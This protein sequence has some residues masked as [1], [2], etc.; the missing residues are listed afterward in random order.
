MESPVRDG[1]SCR[2]RFDP[3]AGQPA[4]DVILIVSQQHANLR[5]CHGRE[6]AR[7]ECIFE[8]EIA[9]HVND[10]RHHL[11]M[12]MCKEQCN[13][14]SNRVA[15]NMATGITPSANFLCQMIRLCLDGDG[16]HWSARV[17]AVAEHVRNDCWS[18]RKETCS[19]QVAQHLKNAVNENNGFHL[20]SAARSLRFPIPCPC[21]LQRRPAPAAEPRSW[22]VGALAARAA[23]GLNGRRRVRRGSGRRRRRICSRANHRPR[24]GALRRDIPL[25]IDRH[26]DWPLTP[27]GNRNPQRRSNRR[28]LDGVELAHAPRHEEALDEA[29]NRRNAGPEEAEIKYPQ[30]RA[31]HIKMVRAKAAEEKRKQNAHDLVATRRVV[32]LV[33]NGLRVGVCVR[34]HLFGSPCLPWFKV[35]NLPLAGSGSP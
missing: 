17:R 15:Q 11:R 9:F 22:R 2:C 26:V 4:S 12:P 14:P 24:H 7:P 30:P 5:Q 8:R 18:W 33:K 35:R 3:G 23:C 13:G 10:G 21:F 29:K 6:F 16:L 20:H 27:T 34:A 31:A 32:L 28:C 1:H 19:G 25:Y